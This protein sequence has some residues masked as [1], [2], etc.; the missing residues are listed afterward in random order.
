MRIGIDVS[1]TGNLKAGC[2]FYADGL[3]RHLAEI[4]QKNEYILYPTFGDGFWDPNW[5]SGIERIHQ[6]NFR[7]LRGHKSYSAA[8]RFW[9]Q[10][11]PEIEKK[12]GNPQIIHS[13]NFFCPKGLRQTYLV[14]TLYDLSFLVH[15][16]WTTE[17]N[18]QTCFQGVF[19]ASLQAD[20]IIAISEF[21]LKNFLSFFPH[22]PKERMR[23]IYPGSRFKEPVGK[24]K[25]SSL[26]P[27][28]KDEFW[29]TVG[30]LEPRKNHRS[31][32]RAYAELKN[33]FSKTYP[34]VL[35]GGQGWLIENLEK[36]LEA[37]Q[38]HRD[39]IQ[40]GYVDD[41]SLQWLY[42]NCY[43]FIYPSFFEGFGLP[44][45]EAM[46]QG[47]PVVVSSSSSLLEVV[48]D[49]GLHIDPSNEKELFQ[50]MLEFQ[51]NPELRLNQKKK[52]IQQA[53]KFSWRKAAEKALACYHE[54]QQIGHL[55]SSEDYPKNFPNKEKKRRFLLR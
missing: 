46:S 11:D 36:E 51:R 27:L 33:R 48:D 40:L 41:E 2:G 20:L 25:P 28:S 53:A 15:P 42:E 3:V 22:Y 31:L 38:I 1:Q 16:E 32:L 10:S 19:Q 26:P 55:L 54:V 43:A 8:K 13:N 30:I 21:T 29:L 9:T 37:L 23:I 35:A 39:V 6:P 18:R 50:A 5:S 14:Y 52:S 17:E 24:S 49:C 4:D 44:V 47:A 45:L 34:L 12:L 7:Y